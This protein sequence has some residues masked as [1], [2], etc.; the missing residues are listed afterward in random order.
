M[1]LLVCGRHFLDVFSATAAAA[2]ERVDARTHHVFSRQHV[3]LCR[4]VYLAFVSVGQLL[5]RCVFDSCIRFSTTVALRASRYKLPQ[6]SRRNGRTSLTGHA[7][8]LVSLRCNCSCSSLGI[9]KSCSFCIV[10]VFL[11]VDDVERKNMSEGFK[12]NHPPTIERCPVGAEPYASVCT[13]DGKAHKRE[14]EVGTSA[15]LVRV[16]PRKCSL[17]LFLAAP[18]RASMPR[19]YVRHCCAAEI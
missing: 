5:L 16:A 12:L 7:C 4:M 13:T 19:D 18:S 11:L 9:R 8:S 14:T 3:L 1:L 17:R 15:L 6:D 2:S 10:R